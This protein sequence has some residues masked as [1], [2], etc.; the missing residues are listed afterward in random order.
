M[1]KLDYDA[2]LKEFAATL[3]KASVKLLKEKNDEIER[4]RSLCNSLA[5]DHEE[6]LKRIKRLSEALEGNDKLL[7]KMATQYVLDHGA[8]ELFAKFGIAMEIK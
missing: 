3:D 1:T 4:L 5:S 2:L 8:Q 7:H 6:A